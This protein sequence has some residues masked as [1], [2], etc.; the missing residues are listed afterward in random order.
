MIHHTIYGRLTK[1][2]ITTD[3]TPITK[4]TKFTKPTTLTTAKTKVVTGHPSS[5]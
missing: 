2:L 1:P 5:P 4:L 3:T